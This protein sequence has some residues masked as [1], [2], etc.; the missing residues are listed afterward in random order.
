MDKG[1]LVDETPQE[2]CDTLQATYVDTAKSII[3]ANCATVG[4]HVTGFAHGDF[5]TYAG[6]SAQGVLID[7]DPGLGGRVTSATSPMP[8]QGQLPDSLRRVLEC[9]ANDGYPQQ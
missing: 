3:N 4:C 6:M 7:G 5:T 8:P 9:W 1:E 2:Y